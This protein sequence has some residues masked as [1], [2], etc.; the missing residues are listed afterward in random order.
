MTHPTIT[1]DA[2]DDDPSVAQ[3]GVVEDKVGVTHDYN[4]FWTLPDTDN[5]ADFMLV[6]A[7][8]YEHLATLGFT[9]GI[10]KF[11]KFRE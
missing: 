9:C 8:W 10:P 2:I 7:A 5:M 3:A 11:T 4:G 6:V 1:E